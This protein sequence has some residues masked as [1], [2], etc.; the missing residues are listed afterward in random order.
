VGDGPFGGDVGDLNGDGFLDLAVANDGTAADL[1]VLLGRGD[2]T[3]GDERRLA[4][5]G[6]PES[7]KARDFNGDGRLDLVVA[8]VIDLSVFLGRGDGTFTDPTLYPAGLVPADVGRSDVHG[9][10]RLGLGH[11]GPDSAVV[12]LH[13]GPGDA[14]R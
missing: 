8:N 9:D 6:A 5:G 12:T 7:V 13:S 14:P 3:F 1:S 11:T 10:G 4:V 2:G